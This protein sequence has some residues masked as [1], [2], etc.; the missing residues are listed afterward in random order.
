MLTPQLV[1]SESLRTG[2]CHYRLLP[3]VSRCFHQ[4]KRHL[5]TTSNNAALELLIPT[6]CVG[7]FTVLLLL[8]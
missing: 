4:L 5:A 7:A 1:F 6:H 2:P 8:F 3:H